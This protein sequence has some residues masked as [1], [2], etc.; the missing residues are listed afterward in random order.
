[1]FAIEAAEEVMGVGAALGG[2]AFDAGG[3]EVAVGVAAAF[4]ARDD[5]IQASSAA[6][7]STKA[8]ETEAAVASVNSTAMGIILEE[9][10]LFE[11]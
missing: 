3:D 10:D 7:E 6:I 2:V 4:G 11:V 9:I 1:V 8:I 5:V